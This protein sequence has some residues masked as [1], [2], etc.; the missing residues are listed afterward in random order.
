MLFVITGDGKGKT[1]CSLGMVNRALGNNMR[2]CIFQFIKNTASDTGEYKF[3]SKD[4]LWKNFGCG[5]T[6]LQNDLSET[7]KVCR[8]GWEEF[9][10][11]SVSNKWDFIVL[12]EF[13]YV[14][15]NKFIPTEEVVS[16]L[17]ENHD[18]EGFPHVVITGRRASQKLLDICDTASE[19]KEIKHHFSKT[20]K[21]IKGIEF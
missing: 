11:E 3:L 1:T 17:N 20:K 2:C 7:E 9:K 18:K 14:M 16:F 21:A 5:F 12:D 15:E 10:K 6:W 19:I 13:T 4:V 8:E